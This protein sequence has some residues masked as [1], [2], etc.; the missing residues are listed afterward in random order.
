MPCIKATPFHLRL[1]L[2]LSLTNPFLSF[3]SLSAHPNAIPSLSFHQ[4][5]AFSIT[6]TF[7]HFADT[8]IQSDLQM[9]TLEAV[10]LTVGQQT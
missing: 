3:Q 10:K 9:T 6:F 5:T 2:L 8:F 7:I 4:N 1:S